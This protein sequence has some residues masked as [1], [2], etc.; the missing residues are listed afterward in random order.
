MSELNRREYTKWLLNAMGEGKYKA[1]GYLELRLPSGNSTARGFTDDEVKQFQD[2]GLTVYGIYVYN[3]KLLLKHY[4]NNISLLNSLGVTTYQ[5]FIE[6]L[7]KPENLQASGDWNCLAD[8]AY[9]DRGF[10]LSRCKSTKV[11]IDPDVK[12]YLEDSFRNALITLSQNPVRLNK[13]LKSFFEPKYVRIVSNNI[14]GGVKN[15]TTQDDT[16]I[17]NTAFKG[18]PTLK[19]DEWE[20]KR[21][22]ERGELRH[23]IVIQQTS[24]SKNIKDEKTPTVWLDYGAAEGDIAIQTHKELQRNKP[25]DYVRGFAV[26]VKEWHGHSNLSS[27]KD[28]KNLSAIKLDESLLSFSE[29]YDLL[30]FILDKSVNVIFIEMVLH[31]LT[32][33]DKKRVYGTFYRILADDGIVVVREHGPKTE[34]DIAIIQVQHAIY[35]VKEAE[36]TGSKNPGDDYLNSAYAEYLSKEAWWN[37]WNNNGFIPSD[38]E[39]QYDW[40]LSKVHGQASTFYSILK[41]NL[42]LNIVISSCWFDGYSSDRRD[43]MAGKVGQDLIKIYPKLNLTENF[44]DL[45]IDPEVGNFIMTT[46]GRK[47]DDFYIKN[48][49]ASGLSSLQLIL[50]HGVNPVSFISSLLKQFFPGESI[51]QLLLTGICKEN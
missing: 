22:I 8:V 44:Y 32:E 27:I 1:I 12:R 23:K 46:L 45:E 19:D 36:A 28:V 11:V 3:N 39:G 7:V 47:Y 35:G 30:P 43:I 50:H 38:L 5:E 42:Q 14:Q 34:E 9:G 6:K 15:L 18:I 40:N 41:K 25:I 21:A 20:K 33:K 26:D 37:E 31:H 4:N 48:R 2:K 51:Q 17:Y 16:D 49:I 24:V 13:L 29:G 10:Y